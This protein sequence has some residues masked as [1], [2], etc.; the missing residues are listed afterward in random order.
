M[1]VLTG[2]QELFVVA[3]V[4]ALAPLVA[5]LIPHQRVP[6]VVLLLLGG[7]LIGPDGLGI[8][9]TQELELIA[10]V[11]LGFVF[12]LAGFEIDP[13]ML[14]SRLGQAGRGRLGRRRWSPPSGWSVSWPRSATS[15]R[16]CPSPWP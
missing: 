15:T 16:S 10:N 12:L 5:A 6:Q 3:L 2:L 7:M 11:G 9:S 8:D 13:A 1:D 4:S 14:F